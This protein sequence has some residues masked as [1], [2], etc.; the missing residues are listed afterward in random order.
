MQAN[1]ISRPFSSTELKNFLLHFKAMMGP[2]GLYQHATK[3]EPL[4][5]EGY[6][7]DDN[8]RAV[9]TLLYLK[10]LVLDKDQVEVE[11]LLQKCWI[12]LKEAEEK[13][14][15][16]FNFRSAEGQWLDKDRS[17]DMYARLIRALVLVLDHDDNEARQKEA[18]EKLARLLQHVEVI[19]APRAWSEILIALGGASAL[20]RKQYLVQPLLEYGVD[21][22][23]R[24]WKDTATEDWAWFEPS[25]TYANAVFPHGLL[26]S[27]SVI[28]NENVEKI[29]H[30][31]T[32]FL[33]QTTIEKNVFL[34]IGSEGWYPKG[35]VP[36]RNNQQ[37]IEAGLTFDFLLDYE[38]HFSGRVSVET[39]AAP[40]LW[41]FGHNSKN[42]V[43]VDEQIGACLDGIFDH[44]PNPNY[45]AESMLA[46]QWAEIRLRLAPQAVQNYIK[47]KRILG[48]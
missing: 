44:G 21:R 17:D 43:M 36:S 10:K 37:A 39:I 30:A 12:F 18:K 38:E 14:G 7:T 16:Y 13:P 40:Y 1:T 5:S 31:S 26:M 34:P 25:M 2:H 4:L 19:N 9:Q 45:G 24:L 46:Y 20:V 15:I 8:A 47:E 23:Q 32:G 27:R 11:E 3:R 29:L 48:V 22:L 28:R 33:L 41:F 35:G 6:C 42:I